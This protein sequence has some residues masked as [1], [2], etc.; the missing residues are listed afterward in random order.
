KLRPD[1]PASDEYPASYVYDP[2]DP[3]PTLGGALL[4]PGTYARGPV[5]QQEI[6]ERRD[7]LTYT[8]EVLAADTE[9]TGSVRAILHA[10]TSAPDTDWVLKLCDVHPDGRTFNVCDGIARARYRN[11]TNN[12][13]LLDP[14][15]AEQYEVDLWATSIV[16]K[17]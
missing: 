2:Q 15:A 16:F 17:A 6:I 13:A 10:S 11:G 8:S 3:C 12:P 5:N 14:G 7:V 4:M 1:A 9:V